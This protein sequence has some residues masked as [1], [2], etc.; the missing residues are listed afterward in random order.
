M[1]IEKEHIMITREFL[2]TLTFR[3]MTD[4]D[5]TGFAG[6]M[7]PIPL[8]AETEDLLVVIDGDRCEVYNDN[9]DYGPACICESITNLT[10]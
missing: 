3:V 1:N 2:S 8:I 7:S 6:V 4:S 9:S 5:K 10:Y